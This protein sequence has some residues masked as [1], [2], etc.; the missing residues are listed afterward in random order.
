[1]R[2]VRSTQIRYHI[3]RDATRTTVTLDTIISDLLALKLGLTPATSEAHTAAREWL[4]QTYDEIGD[5]DAGR[6][7]QTLQRRA[8]LLIADKKLS[9]QY[10][11]WFLEP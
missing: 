6:V 4:Q 11:N 2:K 5:H 9:T 1:M 8:V 10:W 7:S 3:L